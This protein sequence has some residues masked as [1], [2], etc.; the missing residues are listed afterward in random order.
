MAFT[1]KML[2]AM[3]IDEE[4]IDEIIEAHL[5][6]TNA[7]KDKADKLDS[8]QRQLDDALA[9]AKDSSADKVSKKD[10]DN[11]KQQFDDYKSAAEAE[12]SKASKAALYKELLKSEGIGEKWIERAVRF[13]DIAGLEVDENGKLKGEEK[14]RE[15]I[16]ADF[17]DI[18]ETTHKA[19]AKVPNPPKK[20]VGK[21]F[22]KDD[23][24]KMSAKEINENYEQ[25][26]ESLKKGE[27]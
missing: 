2:K 1:R 14:L 12:K 15:Q 18:I 5:E 8:V 27:N 6:V 21:S 7:L 9:A 25:I 16:K 10:Y 11:L 20:E 24:R 3:G 13:S 17:G 4:K 19:G 26:I 22:T 23:I